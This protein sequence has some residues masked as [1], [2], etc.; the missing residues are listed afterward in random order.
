MLKLVKSHEFTIHSFLSSAKSRFNHTVPI[1]DEVALG[2]ERVIVMPIE[3][4]L[5][6]VVDSV[7]KPVA[8]ILHT[9]S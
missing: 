4:V 9:S 1:L 3:T 6:D 2:V 5:P 7:S 8:M